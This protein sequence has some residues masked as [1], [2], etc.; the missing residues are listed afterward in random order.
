MNSRVLGVGLYEFRWF[1][2]EL[3]LPWRSGVPSSLILFSFLSCPFMIFLS[4][5][6]LSF[7]SMSFLP[8]DLNL[9]YSAV[10][11]MGILGVWFPHYS[12]MF[13]TCRGTCSLFSCPPPFSCPFLWCSFPF[14][15]FPF[16]LCLFCP[17]IHIWC[18][19]HGHSM[20]VFLNYSHVF[21]ACRA[22]W[23][24]LFSYP[25]LFSCPVLL[26]YS[27]PFLSFYVFFAHWSISSVVFIDIL[28]VFFSTIATC[29]YPAGEP[30]SPFLAVSSRSLA[31]SFYKFHFPFHFF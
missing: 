24:S 8:I 19:F 1:P 30:G 2:R 16:L 27:F 31:P 11:S 23:S 13:V 18:S 15:F 14:L 17:L 22:I 5:P 9:L 21:V 28:C 3:C 4:F 12:H 26:W 29:F 6:F 10:V 20:C 7:P 25:L